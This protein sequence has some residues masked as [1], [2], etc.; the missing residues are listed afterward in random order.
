MLG[1]RYATQSDMKSSNFEHIEV[2]YSH[3]AYDFTLGYR[4]PIQYM[5]SW[6]CEHTQQR[7]SA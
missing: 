2:F 3:R 7:L 5:N 1:M 4:S 6:I